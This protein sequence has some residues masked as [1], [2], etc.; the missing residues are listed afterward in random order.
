MKKHCVCSVWE[1]CFYKTRSNSLPKGKNSLL[2]ISPSFSGK[3][4]AVIYTE[5]M[6]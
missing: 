4:I 6:A 1:I 5:N 2:K 3:V